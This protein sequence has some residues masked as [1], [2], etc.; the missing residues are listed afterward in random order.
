M[1]NTNFSFNE[2]RLA[3]PIN[4]LLEFR[5]ARDPHAQATLNDLKKFSEILLSNLGDAIQ[6]GKDQKLGDR[7]AT[8]Y[9]NRLRNFSK[10]GVISR[11]CVAMLLFTFANDFLDISYKDF[12]DEN[13]FIDIPKFHFLSIPTAALT[14][15]GINLQRNADK[16]G[17][18]EAISVEEL[19]QAGID[20][21]Y[22]TEVRI[23]QKVFKTLDP[24]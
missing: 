8:T 18:N 6:T 14:S 4:E 15:L 12:T 22:A 21:T 23:K 20:F 10:Q 3:G 16:F 11:G 9:I 2:Q 1:V 19:F 13:Q 17:V 24:K 7:D 5:N